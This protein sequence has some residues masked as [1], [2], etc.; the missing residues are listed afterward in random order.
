MTVRFNLQVFIALIFINIFPVTADNNAGGKESN[1]KEHYSLPAINKSSLEKKLESANKGKETIA[2]LGELATYYVDWEANYIAAD[3]LLKVGIELA[4]LSYDNIQLVEAYSNY[5]IIMDDYSYS[6]SIS[7][8]IDKLE[9]YGSQL[10]LPADI[11]KCKIALAKGY[12]LI[13]KM[14]Q[15]RD[16]SYQALTTAIQLKDQQMTAKTH[17]VVG[18]IQQKMNNNVESIRNFLDALTIAESTQD[19]VLKMDCYNNL[20]KFYNLIKAYDKSIQYKLKELGIAENATNQDS[21]RIMTLKCDLEVIAFNNRTLNEKQLYKIIDFAKRNDLPKLKRNGLVI[22]RSH[23]I[24]Q[25]DFSQLYNLFHKNYP[26][27]L[28][29]IKVNDTTTYYRLE[30]FFRE[31][32]GEIDSAMKYY[33]MAAYRIDNSKDKLRRS[34]FYLRY[35]DFLERRGL[36]EKANEQFQKAYSVASSLPYYE[37]MLDA[38]NK[39][40]KNYL[41][42]GDYLNAYKYSQTNRNIADSLS[43]MVQKEELQLIEIENEEVLREQRLEKSKEETRRRNN[44]QYTA[45]TIIIA[46]AFLLLLILG[47]FKVSP[48]M[49]Q[50]VGFVCFIFFFEFLILLFDTWIH[51]LTHGEPWKILGIKI[52]L[53]CGL[54]PLHHMV[55][56]RIIHYLINNKMNWREQKFFRSR[57]IKTEELIQPD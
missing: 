3:S 44:I 2:A 34:S 12:L 37:F 29:Y 17:L 53:M 48:T 57:K 47:G 10:R 36:A 38:T 39:L 54:L 32:D 30:A 27:E 25:N 28:E 1:D 23:L 24:K 55:E 35:G 41:S 6:S 13:F 9:N 46:S 26:E 20:S 51:H 50:M 56:K 19:V 5:L 33:E 45:I 7:E 40:E 31:H 4:E 49:I 8:I 42:Q 52:L 14:E 18:D 21:L 16:F 43:N 22:F 15:A 11:W